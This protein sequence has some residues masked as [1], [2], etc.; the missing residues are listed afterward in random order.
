[1]E[2]KFKVDTLSFKFDEVPNLLSVFQKGLYFMH[3]STFYQITSSPFLDL[4]SQEIFL[5]VRFEE[6][7]FTDAGKTT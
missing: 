5:T 7:D 1:M 2:R 4:D 3:N 6:H